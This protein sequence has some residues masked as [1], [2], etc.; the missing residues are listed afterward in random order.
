MREDDRL[1]WN[2]LAKP[3]ATSTRRARS[4]SSR[5][6]ATPS[7]DQSHFTSRHYW[8]VGELDDNASDRLDRAAARRHRHAHNPLQGVSLDGYLAPAL[9]TA[10]V[11]VAAT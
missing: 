6:S 1:R 11:P 8:E 3:L 9:A 2:P 5:R 4:P 7:P 10:S